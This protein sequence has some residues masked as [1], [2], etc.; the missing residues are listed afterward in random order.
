MASLLPIPSVIDPARI[1]CG[2]S[3]YKC[4]IIKKLCDPM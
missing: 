4:D 2:G 1:S 3:V